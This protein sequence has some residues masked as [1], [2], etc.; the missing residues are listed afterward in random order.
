MSLYGEVQYIMVNC[1]MGPPCKQ[2]ETDT[3]ENIIFDNLLGTV[4]RSRLD[5]FILSTLSTVTQDYSLLAFVV[6]SPI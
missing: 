1:H 3:I 5:W 2:T 4:K 6:I